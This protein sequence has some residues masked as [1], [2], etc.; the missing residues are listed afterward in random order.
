MENVIGLKVEL[1]GSLAKTGTGHGT[2]KAII[3]GL[4][5]ADITTFKSHQLIPSIEKINLEK[6]LSLL[7]KQEIDFNSYIINIWKKQLPEIYVKNFKMKQE[8][9]GIELLKGLGEG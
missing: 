9:A 6:K 4:T 2:D 5:G 7:G 8:T 1:F 3:M